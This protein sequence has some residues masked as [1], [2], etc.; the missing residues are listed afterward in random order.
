MGRSRNSTDRH[1]EYV[2]EARRVARSLYEE[3]KEAITVEDVTAVSP[4]P[5]GISRHILGSIFRRPEWVRV[6]YK[7]SGYRPNGRRPVGCFV[8]TSSHINP[9]VS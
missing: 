7:N 5:E 3:R 4:L 6:G 8:P 2:T 1:W 9:E